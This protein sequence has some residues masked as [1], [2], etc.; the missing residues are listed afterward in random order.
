M[1]SSIT[2][3]DH[4]WKLTKT[5]GL[6]LDTSPIS[7]RLVTSGYVFSAA[8]TLWDNGLSDST[9]PKYNEVAAGNGYTAGGIVLSGAVATNSKIDYAD[10][11]WFNLT[12]TFRAAVGV[13]NGTFGG[14]VNPVLFYYLPDST[15]ADTASIGSNWVI[16]WSDIN[17]LF[18][19]P[20]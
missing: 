10:L 1:A 5:S 13:A 19:R 7:V 16:L 20:T 11:T 15:P 14:L 6:D 17:G 3:Y 8:H 9:N 2:A 4:L 18:Y 12:K